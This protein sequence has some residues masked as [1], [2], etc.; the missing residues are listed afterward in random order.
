MGK[1]ELGVI[2]ICL[3][4]TIQRA[5]INVIIDQSSHCNSE[6]CERNVERV[7]YLIDSSVDPCEDCFQYACS[8]KNRGKELPYM[9]G[10]KL[11]NNNYNN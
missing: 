4:L 9:L 2:L 8:K 11:Y 5:A 10:R 1:S 7:E 6:D 3:G